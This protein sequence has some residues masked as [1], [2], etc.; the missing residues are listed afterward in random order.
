MLRTKEDSTHGTKILRWRK[1]KSPRQCA[2][3]QVEHREG[4]SLALL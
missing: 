3:D 4:K 1:D 2:M